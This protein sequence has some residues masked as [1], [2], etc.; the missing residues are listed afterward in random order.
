MYFFNFYMYPFFIKT[1]LL[2]CRIYNVINQKITEVLNMNDFLK[3]YVYNMKSIYFY[4]ID[5]KLEPRETPWFHIYS[6]D[7]D[8]QLVQRN[9][10]SF[11]NLLFDLLFSQSDINESRE[12][13]GPQRSINKEYPFSTILNMSSSNP[14]SYFIQ[15]KKYILNECSTIPIHNTDPL[16][17]IKGKINNIEDIYLVRTGPFHSNELYFTSD[18]STAHFFTIEYTHSK[19][20]ESVEL[21]LSN[22]WY[23]V[24]NELFS[25]SFVLRAL[26]HQIKPFYFDELYKIKIMDNNFQIIEFGSDKYIKLSY[27]GYDICTIQ[28]LEM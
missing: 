25:P 15:I 6:L 21:H 13:E 2:Y 20:E 22:S 16:I 7:S 5:R 28:N 26:E 27:D 18:K 24:G 4:M 17:V 8:Q 12:S 9:I 19:M 23:I 1:S 3:N 10:Y 11:S 14:L